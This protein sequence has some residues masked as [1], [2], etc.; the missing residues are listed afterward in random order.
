[1]K[2]IIYKN[3]DNTVGVLSLSPNWDRSFEE[4]AQKDVPEGLPWKVVEENELPKDRYLVSAWM[5][6]D[7]N[8]EITFDLKEVKKIWLNLYRKVRTPLLEKLDL[9]YMRADEAGNLELKKE[10]ATKKQ[11]LRDVTKTELPDNLEGIKNTWPSILGDN[12]FK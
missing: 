4:L 7:I 8:E 10:I 2:Y 3:T 9:E 1:M 6:K 11:A 12:P 5:L